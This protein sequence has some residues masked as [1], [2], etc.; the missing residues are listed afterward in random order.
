MKKVLDVCP[1]YGPNPESRCKT[2]SCAIAG[3]CKITWHDDFYRDCDKYKE[4][5]ADYILGA[6]PKG[7]V[8]SKYRRIVL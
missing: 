1:F 4:N 2:G 5:F 7:D 8:K 3:D 6:G